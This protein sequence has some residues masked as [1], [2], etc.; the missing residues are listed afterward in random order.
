MFDIKFF[1]KSS[2]FKKKILGSGTGLDKNEMYKEFEK[3]RS[4][5]PFIFNIETTNACNMK[6]IMCP[7][8]ALMKRPIRHMDMALFERIIK[9]IV[10]HTQDDLDDF[11][12]YI[13]DEYSIHSDDRN[14][15]S[16][17]FY[18]SSK[19]LTLHGFGEPVLDPCIEERTM[20]CA[21]YGIP[22]YFSCVPAN[23]DVNKITKLMECGLGVIKFSLDALD[24]ETQKKIRGE[25]NDFTGSYRKIC[26]LIKVKSENPS[27]KTEI[28]VTMIELSGDKKSEETHRRFMDLWRDKPVYA[29][30]KSQ[31]NR[32]FFEKDSK[33][34]SGSHYESQYCEFPW[35][36]TT[37]M[38]DG[39]VVP[40]TQDYN[41]EMILGD[42]NTETLEAIWNGSKYDDLRRSH[43]YG[44]FSNGYKCSSRCDLKTVCEKTYHNNYAGKDN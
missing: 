8:P 9:Q 43:I 3:N 39:S 34:T 32:W 1:K 12:K 38:V 33:M 37:V 35:I 14:E 7:R 19:F 16:F 2:D 36:S 13:A 21:K 28:V 40:C 25:K 5:H 22:T 27:I 26:D 10:P 6:C 17:Y 23:I 20:L 41:A 18:Q 11:G 24:N 29:Y 30:I 15:N 44:G 31:D 42:A 4:K